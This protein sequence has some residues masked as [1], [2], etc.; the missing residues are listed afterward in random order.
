MFHRAIFLACSALALTPGPDVRQWLDNYV[1]RHRLCPWAG[2]ADANGGLRVVESRAKSEARALADL[3][4]E[5][6]RLL[7]PR[8][9]PLATT[10]LVCARVRAWAEDFERFDAFV[11]DAQAAM[12]DVS[13]VAF[14]PKF[15]RW[16]ATPLAPGDAVS[17]HFWE[18][19]VDAD[20]LA[21]AQRAADAGGDAFDVP[22]SYRRSARPA[23]AVVESVDPQELGVRTVRVR[24]VERQWVM[25]FD[26]DDDDDDEDDDLA[27]VPLDWV[28][29]ED[30][31]GGTAPLLADNFIHTSPAPVIHVLRGDE[32]AHETERAGEEFIARLQARNA[33]L[34]QRAKR[35]WPGSA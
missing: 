6:A 32:L 30:A 24:F 3:E 14:H 5:A 9:P 2:R 4:R 19:H 33:R 8:A 31:R 26:D 15:A 7:R 22:C 35:I 11:L 16:R 23:R 1:V 18:A 28:A 25:K 27:D 13:L 10:L 12:D 21:A 17:A 34:A 29:R 20:A